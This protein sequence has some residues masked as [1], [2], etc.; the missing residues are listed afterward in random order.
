[1][2]VDFFKNIKL[3]KIIFKN[4]DNNYSSDVNI[5]Y[6]LD[7]DFQ[8]QS[9][10]TLL[11][12]SGNLLAYDNNNS[13][14]EMNN[15]EILSEANELPPLTIKPTIR[16]DETVYSELKF[17]VVYKK[18]DFV[19]LKYDVMLLISD[20]VQKDIVDYDTEGSIYVEIEV[21]KNGIINPNYSELLM[22]ESYRQYTKNNT[23]NSFI[24]A[25]A[26][27]ESYLKHNFQELDKT[28]GEIF[29]QNI[30]STNVIPNELKSTVKDSLVDLGRIRNHLIHGD[31]KATSTKN[32]LN[33]N[34]L[35]IQVNL[36]G[37]DQF[38]DIRKIVSQ[39]QYYGKQFFL[40]MV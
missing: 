20:E 1:M 39:W 37:Q 7:V 21:E 33:T 4:I 28:W 9:S 11:N 12:V 14:L 23:V 18:F 10:Q 36:Y 19:N 27:F 30:V 2:S 38:E 40:N 17:D 26:A 31:K 29:E 32:V 8:R 5:P 25:R 13:K 15:F 35:E 3:D 6:Q 24:F 34:D 16:C 22:L